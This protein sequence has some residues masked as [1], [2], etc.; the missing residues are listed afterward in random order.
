MR[1]W[2]MAWIASKFGVAERL[3]GVNRQPRVALCLVGDG[4]DRQPER[5]RLTGAHFLV[6]LP[7]AVIDHS[8]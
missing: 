7:A 6:L 4:L 3:H 8:L 5:L 2:L 1:S